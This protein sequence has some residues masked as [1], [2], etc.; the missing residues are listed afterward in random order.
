MLN[1]SSGAKIQLLFN[2][3]AAAEGSAENAYSTLQNDKSFL[4]SASPAISK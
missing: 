4:S 1:D 2:N 3:V